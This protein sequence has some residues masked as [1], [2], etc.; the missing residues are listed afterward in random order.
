MD[1]NI[2]TQSEIPTAQPNINIPVPKTPQN[3]PREVFEII[4]K[5]ILYFLLFL[6][7]SAAV[8]W[9][10]NNLLYS[11]TQNSKVLFYLTSY[12]SL[13]LITG[14]FTILFNFIEKMIPHSGLKKTFRIFIAIG[15]PI[16]VLFNIGYFILFALQGGFVYPS[17]GKEFNTA[18]FSGSENKNSSFCFDKTIELNYYI[19]PENEGYYCETP[20]KDTIAKGEIESGCVT[21]FAIYNNDIS[22]CDKLKN[23]DFPAL[24][25]STDGYENC[26][27]EFAISKLDDRYCDLLST[28]SLAPGD[29][30]R[31][32]CIKV[33]A[34]RSHNRS[35][36]EK[37]PT[38]SS[39][40]TACLYY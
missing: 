33:I 25:M 24:G 13:F 20:N 38:S 15:I 30:D 22:Y 34:W 29:S 5:R 11:F 32:Q 12:L 10:T 39:L 18:Y 7:P 9:N 40:K 19:S 16:F 6:L 36:C 14:I 28:G 35:L 1:P 21:S 4:K 27:A 23:Q 3:I 17:C 8:A 31:Y 2:P 37:I 26:I